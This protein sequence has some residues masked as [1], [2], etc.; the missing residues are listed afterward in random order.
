MLSTLPLFKLLADE[1]RLTILLLIYI[2][3]ELCVCELT[4]VLELSQP[5]ISRHLAMLRN[6]GVLSSRRSGKWV[7]YSLTDSS[8]GINE[9]LNVAAQKEATYLSLLAAKLNEIGKRP[10]RVQLCC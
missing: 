4:H 6:A 10:E 3:Q 7:H 5:K 2:H 1:T 8:Q 9:F